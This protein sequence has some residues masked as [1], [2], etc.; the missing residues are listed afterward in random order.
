[1]EHGTWKGTSTSKKEKQA[2]EDILNAK[3]TAIL[4]VWLF[5]TKGKYNVDIDVEVEVDVQTH[6]ICLTWCLR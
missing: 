4:K 2:T 1:M 3:F 6:T 5:I